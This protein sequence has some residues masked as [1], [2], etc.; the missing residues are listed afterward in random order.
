M[1]IPQKDR[2]TVLVALRGW[3]TDNNVTDKAE[4]R[5]RFYQCVEEPDP[6][7]AVEQVKNAKFN[8]FLSSIKN[9][10]GLRMAFP[11]KGRDGNTL[12]H[13]IPGSPDLKAVS[14]VERRLI[15]NSS[16]NARTCGPVSLWKAELS[17]QIVME[18]G[19]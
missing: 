16:S 18:F 19:G 10:Q 15:H 8:H 5:E 14:A 7:K 9:D 13:I 1:K 2:K 12:I 17:G 11:V 3:A 4:L 6:V